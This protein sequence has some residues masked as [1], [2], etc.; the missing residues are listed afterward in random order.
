MRVGNDVATIDDVM[1]VI[2]ILSSR[3]EYTKINPFVVLLG[4]GEYPITSSWTN[5]FG[6]ECAT[7][8]GITRSNIT[9][10]GTGKDTTTILGGFGIHELE[11]ITFKQMTVTQTQIL[12]LILHIQ[13]KNVNCTPTMG[14]TVV[15][16]VE[17]CPNIHGNI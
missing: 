2:E 6:N 8:L 7:T 11:N 16:Q 10:L 3:R 5:Q 17:N 13:V 1:D 4:K 12:H 9:F 14:T 15:H